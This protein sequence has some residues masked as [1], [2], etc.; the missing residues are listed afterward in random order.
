MLS[1]VPK[2][3]Q[4]TG[5]PF[6]RW[7]TDEYFDLIVW[8]EPSGAFFGFQLCYS[9]LNRERALTW[10]R[11]RGYTHKRVSYMEGPTTV[12]GSPLLIPD[13]VF[14][15]RTVADRFRE[16]AKRLEPELVQFVLEKLLRY[17]EKNETKGV[18]Q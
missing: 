2:V 3:R 5:E 1:E 17:P 4:D 10:I 11:G 12:G 18:R 9:R 6:R 7:F 8:Y 14:E 13:G 15:Y 16:E